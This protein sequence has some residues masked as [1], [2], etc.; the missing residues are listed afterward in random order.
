[1]AGDSPWTHGAQALMTQISRAF[2]AIDPAGDALLTEVLRATA[3]H[4][5]GT[6]AVHRVDEDGALPA[7][8]RQAAIPL[9]AF[10]AEL[11]ALIAVRHAPWH[12]DDLALLQEVAARAAQAVHARRTVEAL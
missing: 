8:H 12:A 10:G 7:D 9:V 2:A 6:C 5:G 3:A 1:M 11:G 4:L